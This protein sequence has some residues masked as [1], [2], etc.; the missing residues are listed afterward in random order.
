VVG[1]EPSDALEATFEGLTQTTRAGIEAVA[2][3][4]EEGDS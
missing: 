2:E 4:L 3:R 1:W